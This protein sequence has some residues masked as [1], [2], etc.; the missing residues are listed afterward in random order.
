VEIYLIGDLVVAES[1]AE[2]GKE[3]ERAKTPGLGAEKA[4]GI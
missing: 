3:G 2:R 1:V 4:A